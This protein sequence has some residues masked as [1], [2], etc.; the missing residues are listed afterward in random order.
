VDYPCGYFGDARHA[1][2]C[3]PPQIERYMSRISGPFLDR[4]D[5]HI[6]VGRRLCCWWFVAARLP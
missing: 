6:E 4:I 1:C 3:N 5:L 2:K